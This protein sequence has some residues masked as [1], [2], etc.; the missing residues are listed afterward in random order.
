M[1]HNLQYS[2]VLW[3]ICHLVQRGNQ[4]C[5]FKMLT[6]QPII[7]RCDMGCPSLG[8]IEQP[9]FPLQKVKTATCNTQVCYVMPVTWFKV[10]YAIRNTQVCY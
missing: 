5:P 2:G 6:M 7:H 9:K 8:L 4:K 3:V 10:N 1:I